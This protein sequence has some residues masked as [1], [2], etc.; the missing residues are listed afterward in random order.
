MVA[1]AQAAGADVVTGGRPVGDRGY[2]YAPTVIVGAAQ[3][4]AIVQE[5]CSGRSS[6]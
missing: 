1:Q 6:S 2:F 3:D 4:S 5:G